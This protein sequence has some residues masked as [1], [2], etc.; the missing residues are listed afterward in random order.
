MG[1]CHCFP[2]C[3]L[4][5]NTLLL[6]F[7]FV[8]LFFS[9]F[10]QAWEVKSGS[11]C[12]QQQ[13]ILQGQPFPLQVEYTTRQYDWWQGG[14]D[15]AEN[16]QLEWREVFPEDLALLAFCALKSG[17]LCLEERTDTYQ[18]RGHRGGNEGDWCHDTFFFFGSVLNLYYD[19]KITEY[20][21][22]CQPLY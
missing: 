9:F 1:Y 18:D 15:T 6:L 4:W 3:C 13:P 14:E 21:D 8:F 7:C 5:L 17:Y 19:I 11:H 22:T 16:P 20:L 2:S 10:H 12:V